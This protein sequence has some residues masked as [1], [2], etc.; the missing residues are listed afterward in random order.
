MRSDRTSRNVA[1]RAVPEDAHMSSRSRI[2]SERIQLYPASGTRSS[3]KTERSRRVVALDPGTVAALRAHKARQAAE[4]LALGS[5]YR[6]DGLVFAKVDGSPLHPQYVSD[7]FERHIRDAELP[8][9][10]LH[11]L[12]HSS[13]TLLLDLGVPLKVVS[14]RL[15][16]SSIAI[17]ADT[18][19]HVL[20]HTQDEAATKAGAALLGGIGTK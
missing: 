15:G 10:R 13:A 1:L 2:S 18:Y 4:Q 19:Q 5:G 20:E 9:I 17:T 12:R 8:R 7:A 11:D 3:P 14:E 6:D 16:H